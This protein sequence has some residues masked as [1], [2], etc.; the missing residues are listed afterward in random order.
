MKDEIVEYVTNKGK[1]RYGYKFY[2]GKDPLTGI[3]IQPQKRGF[4]TKKE[5]ILACQKEKERIELG[6]YGNEN[7]RYTVKAFY[8]EMWL[9]NYKDTVKPSS[10]ETVTHV[11]K[12]IIIK[13]TGNMFLD[14]IDGIVATQ[15]VRKWAGNYANSTYKQAT[16][17]LGNLLNYAVQLDIINK[18]Y[19]SIIK[20]P[21]GKIV[22]NKKEFYTRDELNKYLDTVKL[23]GTP[24]QYALFRLM[25]YTGARIGEILALKWSDINFDDETLDINKTLETT[26]KGLIVGSTKTKAGNRVV[27]LDKNTIQVMRNWKKQQSMDNSKLGIIALNPDGL[28]FLSKKGSFIYNQTVFNW[29]YKF[30]KLSGLPRIKL[31]AFRHTHGT[32][33]YEATKDLKAVQERLGHSDIK[34][35][36]NIYVHETE[37][38]KSKSATLFAEFLAE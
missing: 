1:K 5:A 17:Y 4:K 30:S 6:Q 26:N 21:R 8:D 2:A 20:K 32:L 25:A 29:N 13:D 22:E 18:N 37:S 16:A 31:H 19:L 33:L 23:Q 38:K 28:I 34:T 3:S 11:F 36:G 10:L 7:K 14:K 35:T 27:P 24:K 15:I 12:N 9:P